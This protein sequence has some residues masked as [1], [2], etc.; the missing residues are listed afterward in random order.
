M[1]S[2]VRASSQHRIS[3]IADR[4]CLAHVAVIL[5]GIAACTGSLGAI[6]LTVLLFGAL[7]WS[8]VICVSHWSNINVPVVECQTHLDYAAQMA[9][10]LVKVRRFFMHSGR[11]AGAP[12]SLLQLN[13]FTYVLTRVRTLPSLPVFV[14]SSPAAN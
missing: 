14:F 1:H 4:L 10:A 3:R 11:S 8:P 6:V 13:A 7:A 5:C 9:G 2:W 12:P